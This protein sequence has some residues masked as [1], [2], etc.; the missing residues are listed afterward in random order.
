MGSGVPYSPLPTAH[1]SLPSPTYTD[2]MSAEIAEPFLLV[3][4]GG[5]SGSAVEDMVAAARRAAALDSLE[6]ALGTGAF[7]GGLLITDRPVEADLP[8]GLEIVRSSEPFH[9]GEAL[10]QTI[11]QRRLVRPVV[12]GAGALPLL[13]A[14]EFVAI[15]IRL[16]SVDALAITNNFYS[17]DLVAWT[18]GA[19][20]DQVTP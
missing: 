11:R 5:V 3:F 18:P 2:P 16:S 9:F 7:A 4:D 12:F 8:R 6:R 19:A 20:L 17:S 10:A 15:A 14:D 13:T 1:C